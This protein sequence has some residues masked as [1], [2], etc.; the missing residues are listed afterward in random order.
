MT[1]KKLFLNLIL[2]SSIPYFFIACDNEENQNQGVEI[3]TLVDEDAGE[4]ITFK[5]RFNW[6]KNQLE[7]D[8]TYTES[9]EI[10]YSY[11]LVEDERPLAMTASLK[12]PIKVT[13]QKTKYNEAPVGAPEKLDG[14]DIEVTSNEKDEI[15]QANVNKAKILDDITLNRPPLFG[16]ECL[17]AENPEDCSNDAVQAWMRENLD[18]P[19][20]ALEEGHDGYEYATFTVNPNGEVFYSDIEIKSMDKPCE[21]CKKVVKKAILK[22]PDWLPAL[23]NGKPISSE[24]A[25]PVRFQYV[26]K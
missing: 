9:G 11:V 10:K 12:D 4:D 3:E 18:Y 22:M 17:D 7:R 6:D 20:A 14:P 25:L 24:V 2:L 26:G 16:K 23:R 15:P 19:E 8:A 5:E 1:F 21:G 13:P